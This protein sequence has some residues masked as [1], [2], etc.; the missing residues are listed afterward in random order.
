MDRDEA[1]EAKAHAAAAART[2][3]GRSVRASTAGASVAP[4]S[5][6][7]SPRG[8]GG[9]AVALRYRLG[10]PG[11]RSLARRVAAEVSRTGAVVEVRRTGRIRALTDV[12]GASTG[13]GDVGAVVPGPR[14]P[15]ATAQAL[16]ETGRVRPLRPGVSIAHVDV[17]AGTLGAFV[18][19]GG[20][21]HVLSNY[22]VLAGSPAARPGDLVLQPGPADGGYAPRDRVGTLAAV[23]PLTPGTT[24]TVDAAVALLDDTDVDA[25][26]PVGYIT[27]TAQ[28][29][30]GETVGK[31]GR[32]TS[33]TAGRVTAIELDDVVVG[34]GDELG[35]LRF[36][37]QIEIEG[38]GVGPF[39]RG[40]DSGSLVY[41]EDGVALGLLFAGSETGG[42]N[43]RG[44][45]YVNPI[46]AVL[47]A[48][49]A[50]LLA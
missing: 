27:R 4:L 36:D 21:L 17:S 37:D 20:A 32:T 50:T 22:H 45:T 48:L 24:A 16:G 7:L 35:N 11:V 40:G 23:A 44:L 3:A 49:D 41:R 18:L 38:T 13:V 8:D 1:R 30:G 42:D 25:R 6:G 12:G 31:I 39:S 14:P 34:Y 9:Y 29:V 43:G 19:V 10:L 47:G 33:V 46:D 5:V 28:A 15:V 26:Y 2:L